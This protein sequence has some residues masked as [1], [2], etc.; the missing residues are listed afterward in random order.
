MLAFVKATFLDPLLVGTFF[1]ADLLVF[2]ETEGA[3]FLVRTEV[4]SL[5]LIADFSLVL[6]GVFC[7]AF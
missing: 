6:E 5:A 2:T 1:A 4:F 7:L 3:N